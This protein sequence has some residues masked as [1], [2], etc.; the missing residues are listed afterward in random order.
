[1][2]RRTHDRRQRDSV[3]R[4]GEGGDDHRADD[5][6]RRVADDAAGGDRRRQDEQHPEL[7]ELGTPVAEVDEE[8]PGDVVQ[9]IAMVLAGVDRPRQPPHAVLLVRARTG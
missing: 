3:D 1:V 9:C 6:R 5:G 7:R 8:A 4:R 2:L